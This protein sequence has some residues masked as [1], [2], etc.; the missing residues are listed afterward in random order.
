MKRRKRRREGGRQER[1]KDR[2]RRNCNSYTGTMSKP[3]KLPV[4]AQMA[5]LTKISKQP[6]KLCSKN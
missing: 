2:R 1:R 3:Q 4:R 5:D 6:F